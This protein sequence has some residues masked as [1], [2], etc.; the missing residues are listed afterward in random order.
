MTKTLERRQFELRADLL[1]EG[2]GGF[3]G[4]AHRKGEIDAYGDIAEGENVYRNLPEFV[5]R[6]FVPVGHDWHAL[7]VA[8]VK[9][10]KEDAQGL[11]IEAAFHSDPEG[12]RAR[13]VVTERLDAGKFVGLSIG[14]W[15]TDTE[16]AQRDGKDLRIVRGMDLAEVSIVTVPAVYSAGI[17]EARGAGLPFADHLSAVLATNE[18]LAH[19]FAQLKSL[20]EGDGREF[21]EEKRQQAEQFMEGLRGVIAEVGELLHVPEVLSAPDP[22]LLESLARHGI[23]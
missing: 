10:A 19:R 22:A 18:G 14:F 16:K 2:S 15:A 12:Q 4:Y 6:G 11:W 21:S 9:D 3:K 20:R 7:P 5:K 1:T 13:T 8:L 23:R 17:H